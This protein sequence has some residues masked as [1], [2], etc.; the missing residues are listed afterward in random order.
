MKFVGNELA[1]KMQISLGSV[2]LTSASALVGGPHRV[3]DGSLV[4]SVEIRKHESCPLLGLVAL[5]VFPLH[6]DPGRSLS[7][8]TEAPAGVSVGIALGSAAR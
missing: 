4:A 1:I 2:P 8:A 6:A 3:G 5:G 7:G